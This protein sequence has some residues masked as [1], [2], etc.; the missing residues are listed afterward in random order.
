MAS[1][2]TVLGNNVSVSGSFVA[3]IRIEWQ[4]AGQNVGGN[5]STINWQGYVDFFGCDAQ[6]DNGH[7]N[8]SG[9]TALYNNGGRVYNYAGNSSNH[10]VGMGSG[11]FNIGHDGAGNATLGL[12]GSVAVYQSGTSSGSGAW[13]LPTINRYSN[14]TGFGVSS[15]TDEGFVLSAT[16]DLSASVINFSIDGGASYSGGGSGTSASQAFHN[17]KSGYTYTC[18]VQT[19]NA[20]S[21]LQQFGGPITPT[22]AVQ[23]NFFKVRTI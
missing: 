4:L 12:D 22:T 13:G 9:V 11:S 6:L 14:V 1:S 7:V 18:Y 21:G 2:G 5:Y 19:V 17:L 10:T 23:N 3:R 15:I 8:W 16:C 20:S